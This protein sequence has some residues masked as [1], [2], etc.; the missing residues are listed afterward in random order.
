[1]TEQDIK[2]AWEDKQREKAAELQQAL[3]EAQQTEEEL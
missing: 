1:M 2:Q 3:I